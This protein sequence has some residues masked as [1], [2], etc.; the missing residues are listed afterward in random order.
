M[1]GIDGI[2]VTKLDGTAK[3]GALFSISNQLELPIFYIG[4]GEKQDDLIEFSPE[5]FVDSLLDEI[6]TSENS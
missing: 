5:E 6:Y 3:G 2:I 4:I 1:V